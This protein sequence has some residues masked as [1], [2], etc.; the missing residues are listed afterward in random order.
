MK[1]PPYYFRCLLTAVVCLTSSAFAL[2]PGDV[3]PTGTAVPNENPDTAYDLFIIC[4]QSNT[5]GGR[6]M[7]PELDRRFNPNAWM[8]LTIPKDVP[9]YRNVPV[10]AVEPMYVVGRTDKDNFIGFGKSFVDCLTEVA[11]ERY[12]DHDILVFH[13]GHPGSGFTTNRRDKEPLEGIAADRPSPGNW[14]PEEGDLYQPMIRRVQ[15]IQENVPNVRIAGIL[16]HQGEADCRTLTREEWFATMEAFVARLRTDL[17]EREL[18][19]VVGGMVPSWC[20]NK[21]YV[22]ARQ[23]DLRNLPE[24]IAHTG[25]ADPF[26]KS[27]YEGEEDPDE[28]GLNDEPE[29]ARNDPIHFGAQSH[30]LFGKRYVEGYMQALDNSSQ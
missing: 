21:D 3:I 30:R 13:W 10:A 28:L 11:P 15:L 5:K 19:F 23:E 14:R 25:Y 4:G 16:W 27:P 20:R 7:V 18:P 2:E 17:G 9:E 29:G 12:E 6:W 22:I 26:N 8:I 24:H 1:V